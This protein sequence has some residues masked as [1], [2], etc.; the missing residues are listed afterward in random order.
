MHWTQATLLVPAFR[1]EA[2]VDLPLPC[3][4]DF[5][6]SIAKYFES[7]DAGEVPLTLLFSGTVFHARPDGALSAAPLPWTSEASFALPVSVYRDAYE[8]HHPDRVLL[9]I[10][11]GVLERLRRYKTASGVATWAQAIDALLLEREGRR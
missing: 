9:A 1:G 5:D 6:A 10:P 11:R 4:T 8:R 7:L 2:V 3:G